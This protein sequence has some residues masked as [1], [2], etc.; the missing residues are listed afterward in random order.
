MPSTNQDVE[1]DV[2]C[3][4]TTSLPA[5]TFNLQRS[6]ANLSC[7]RAGSETER[8]EASWMRTNHSVRLRGGLRSRSFCR[9]LSRCLRFSAFRPRSYPLVT[10]SLVLAL[11]FSAVSQLENP[12]AT[13]LIRDGQAA[14]EAGDFAHAASDFEQAL[15]MAPGNLEANRGLLLSYLQEKRLDDA[16][17]LGLS[18][19]ARWPRDGQLL[20]WL[21]LVYFKKGRT[22]EALEMLHRAENLDSSQSDTHFDTALVL[23]SDNQYPAAADELE[24]AIQLDPKAALPHLLLGRAYQNTNRSLQAVQQFQT[25]LRLQ[26]DIALGHYHLGFAYAS[27]GRNREAIAEYEN[28]L[29]RSPDHPLVL[30]QLGHCLLAA[31]DW[32]SA[33]RH[34][35][36]AAE[37][38][39]QNS[40]VSYDLGKALLLDGDAEGAVLALRGAVRL[41]SGDPSAHYQLA[42]ALEKTGRKEEAQQEF[43]TFAALKKAQPAQGGM[44]TGP[45]Q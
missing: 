24:K 38:D 3:A 16:E 33:V 43:R 37:I 27:L 8:G 35:Q 45:I 20:H 26:H 11:A 5:T 39:P 32:R 15:R 41:H 40:D 28:E 18:A 22:A 14:L 30:S 29:R 10:L 25:A 19:V 44:A 34:L 1:A 21:G 4:P 23:L 12:P 36:R 6:H 31:G 13:S 42:R 9:D 7:C 17:T 2:Y